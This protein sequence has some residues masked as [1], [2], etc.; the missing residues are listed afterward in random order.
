[1][2]SS[3]RENLKMGNGLSKIEEAEKQ[4]Y[5]SQMMNYQCPILDIGKRRGMTGYIDFIKLSEIDKNLNVVKGQDLGSRFFMV[6]K[7]EFLYTDGTT[8]KT[9]ST[10]FQRYND[11][12]QLWHC[13]GSDG[14]TLMN[15]EG[16]MN[17]EQFSL[18][19][20]LLKKGEVVLNSETVHRTYLNC[21]HFHNGLP[22]NPYESIYPIAL[23]L[24]YSNE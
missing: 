1:M 10:F 17:I 11:S 12:K 24:G 23:K 9:F 21:Q 18:L 19:C 14:V 2:F 5:V 16:G 3:S 20:E 4:E 13:C 15:T 6:V 7:C 8:E 22:N